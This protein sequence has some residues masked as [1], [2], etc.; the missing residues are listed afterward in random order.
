MKLITACNEGYY[1]RMTPYLESLKRHLDFEPVLVTVGFEPEYCPITHVHLTRAQNAGAPY[2]TES[3]QHGSFLQVIDGPDDE[4]LI[5]TDGDIV[6]QRPLTEIEHVQLECLEGAVSC[7]WNSGPTETLQIEAARLYPRVTPLQLA[8]RMGQRVNTTPCYN[9]GVIAAK[10]AT[11]QRIYDA[12]VPLWKTV[13]E[14]FG[15]PARQQWLVNY[16]IDALGI[17]VRRMSYSLHAN[18]HYGIPPGVELRD[19]LAYYQGELVA[20][21]HKL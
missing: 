4:T 15:H 14:A 18:G 6:L 2:E 5:F 10:R 21:R 16:V 1:R 8:A 13:T 11:W 3:P 9:I 12:Y 20:W 17:P 7:G 19:G